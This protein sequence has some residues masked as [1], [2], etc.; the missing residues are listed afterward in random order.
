MFDQE[1]SINS[2]LLK[3][4]R[5]GLQGDNITYEIPPVEG[6]ILISTM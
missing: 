4:P 2:V 5:W 1:S 3:S 6:L